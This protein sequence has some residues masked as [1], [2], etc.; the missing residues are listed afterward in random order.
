MVVGGVVDV[1]PAPWPEA[2][3]VPGLPVPAEPAVPLWP[4]AVVPIGLPS[5]VLVVVEPPAV[6]PI[7]ELPVSL[8]LVPGAL[9]AAR[10]SMT[11]LLMSRLRTGFM[12][13]SL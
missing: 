2:P 10:D 3:V 5:V 12:I 4:L 11:M 13:I 7:A 1:A 9:H 8:P 6:E